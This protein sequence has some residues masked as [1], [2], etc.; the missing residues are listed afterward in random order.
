MG[1]VIRVQKY[2]LPRQRFLNGENEVGKERVA[3]PPTQTLDD[4]VGEA[5]EFEDGG[6]ET[7]EGVQPE[8]TR[9]KTRVIE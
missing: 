7:A 9:N 8:L 6:S 1:V 3:V 5:P 4:V 2:L